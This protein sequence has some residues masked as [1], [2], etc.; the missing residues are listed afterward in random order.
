MGAEFATVVTA[1]DNRSYCV[2]KVA[3]LGKLSPD[4]FFDLFDEHFDNIAY[5]CSDA[6]SVYEDYCQL[7]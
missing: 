6:N 4:L 3:S 5:L 2:C 1:I 7:M